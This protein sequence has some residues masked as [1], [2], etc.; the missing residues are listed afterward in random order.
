MTPD[1]LDHRKLWWW[2]AVFL[3]LSL[4]MILL[5]PNCTNYYD[6]E[7]HKIRPEAQRAVTTENKGPPDPNRIAEIREVLEL[8]CF[9]CKHGEYQRG[10]NDGVEYQRQKGCEK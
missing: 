9:A 1:Q 6:R 8:L 4:A 7:T 10:Y 3:V 2:T 5:G